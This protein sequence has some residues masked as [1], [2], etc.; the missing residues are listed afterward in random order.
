MA[1]VFFITK[2][3]IKEIKYTKD[4]LFDI[5]NVESFNVMKQKGLVSNCLIWTGFRKSVPLHLREYKSNSVMIFDLGNNRCC[6]CCSS[7]IKFE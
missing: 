6:H 3:F 5:N 7:L 4:L 1:K 2:Y